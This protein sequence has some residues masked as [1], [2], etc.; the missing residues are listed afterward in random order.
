MA[1]EAEPEAR[2]QGVW[3]PEKAQLHPP[4]FTGQMETGRAKG[5]VELRGRKG[6]RSA[7]VLGISRRGWKFQKSRVEAPS[8]EKTLDP[9]P[10]LGTEAH[11]FGGAWVA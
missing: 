5:E 10:V 7:L 4:A 1:G 2:I 9:Q 11:C 8:P 3:L 6:V